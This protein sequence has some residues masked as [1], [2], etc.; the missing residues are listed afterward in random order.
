MSVEVSPV[1]TASALDLQ[2]RDLRHTKRAQVRVTM[3]AQNGRVRVNNSC[4]VTIG[5]TSQP[6]STLDRA[7]V[8]VVP[9]APTVINETFGLDL[10]FP[11]PPGS[12]QVSCTATNVEGSLPVINVSADGSISLA[13]L[14][15]VTHACAP[16]STTVCAFGRFAI[17][18]TGTNAAGQTVNGQVAPRDRYDD[19]GI[20]SFFNQSVPDLMVQVSDSCSRYNFYGIY[21]AGQT[22]VTHAFNISVTD[23]R[24]GATRTYVNPPGQQVRSLTDAEAF[25]TCP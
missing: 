18:I 23:T 4:K 2:R 17:S 10:A 7:N 19:G 25:A 20:F 5:S 22:N 12:A 16:G 6:I 15:A 13:E 3:R 8:E 1:A 24:T 21:V 9:E 14:P 11:G